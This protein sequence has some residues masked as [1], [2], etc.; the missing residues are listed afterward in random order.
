MSQVQL[1]FFVVVE[2]GED[3][4]IPK[5]DEIVAESERAIRKPED[6][7]Q[8]DRKMTEKEEEDEEYSPR[9][10]HNMEKSHEEIQEQGFV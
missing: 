4:Q 3:F 6:Q 8:A 10:L 7:E 5:D 2:E 1:S 9:L